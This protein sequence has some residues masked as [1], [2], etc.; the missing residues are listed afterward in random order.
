MIGIDGLPSGTY[1][2]LRWDEAA[3]LHDVVAW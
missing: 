2:A 3:G 1:W